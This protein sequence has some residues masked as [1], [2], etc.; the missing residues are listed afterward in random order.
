MNFQGKA[1]KSGIAIIVLSVLTFVCVFFAQ[2]KE[3]KKELSIGERFHY[4]TS[5]T[6]KGVLGDMFRGKPK[7]PSQYKKFMAQVPEFEHMIYEDGIKIIKFWFS[8]SKDVQ[9]NRFESRLA[10]PLK[11]WKYSPVDEKGQEMW[12]DYTMYKDRMFGGTHTTYSPWIIVKANDK[13]T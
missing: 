7:K 4:E 9:Q 13:K 6:W 12:D 11:R 8:I 2:A 3:K 10:N 5:L 1:V